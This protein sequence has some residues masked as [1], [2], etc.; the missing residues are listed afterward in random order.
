MPRQPRIDIEGQMY[1]VISRGIERRKIFLGK[2]DYEDFLI[3]LK[4]ALNKTD[5][6]CLAWCLMP[7]HFHLLIIREKRPLAELMRRLMTGY[8]VNFNIRH[9]RAGYLFQNRYKAILCQEEEYLMALTAYIH[10]NPLRAKIVKGYKKLSSYDWCG[11]KEIMM[12]KNKE[13]IIDRKYIL[14]H[15]GEKERNALQNY[16]NFLKDQYGKQ[17]KGEYSG[18]GLIKSMG[19]IGNVLSSKKDGAKEMFDERILGEGNFVESVLKEIET[20][21]NKTMSLKEIL[22]KVKRITAIEYKELLGKSRERKIV[23]GRA[24]YCYLRK[25][26]GGVTGTRLMKELKLASGTV[27]YLVHKGRGIVN[28]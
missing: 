27:S 25:E 18:G 23:K 24:V 9:K 17:K 4:T 26:K 1:H 12:E 8:A 28:N 7:N 14:S 11:H 16:E 2:E 20:T 15:F 22:K 13:R 3:R 19:G 10:L 6:K 5:A 21:E